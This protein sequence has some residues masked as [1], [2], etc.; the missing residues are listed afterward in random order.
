M[1]RRVLFAIGFALIGLA[2][3][4]S[5]FVMTSVIHVANRGELSRKTAQLSATVAHL[6]TAYL[7]GSDAVTESY[8]KNLGY[9]S[10]SDKVFVEKKPVVTFQD[11]R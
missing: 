7:A 4:Y 2:A 5:Y 9:V 10:P 8:A 1:E 6:E 3:L 11:A